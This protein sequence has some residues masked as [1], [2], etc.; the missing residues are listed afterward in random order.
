MLSTTT[1]TL[2]SSSYWSRRENFSVCERQGRKWVNFSHSLKV[3]HVRDSFGLRSM[4]WQNYDHYLQLKPHFNEPYRDLAGLAQG[5][6]PSDWRGAK[7]GE[8]IWTFWDGCH[9]LY[10]W[11]HPTVNSFW[12]HIQSFHVFNI[13]FHVVILRSR[14]LAW[15]CSVFNWWHG[16]TRW[17]RQSEIHLWEGCDGCGTTHDQ[18]TRGVGSVQ[19]VWERHAF[20]R[21]GLCF[22]HS[23]LIGGPI[24]A[25]I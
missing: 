11:A 15:I 24:F 7:P 4:S 20:H 9:R 6:N 2:I 18:G 3:G 25:L 19:R 13:E 1:A 5:W 17:D 22:N 12:L 10:L 14:D 21:P 16:L 8:S 23:A